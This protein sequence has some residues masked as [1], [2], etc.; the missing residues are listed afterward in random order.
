MPR[1]PFTDIW[2]FLTGATGD[3]MAL[4]VW[5]Y[6]LMALF[7]ALILAS[8]VIAIR[9]WRDDPAQRTAVHFGTWFVRVLIGC[10]WFEGMLWKLPL[11]VSPGLQYWVEQ[12]AKRAAFEFHRDFVTNFIIP[13]LYLFNPLVFLAEFTFAVSLILGL[14]VRLVSAVA[15]L[16][17]LNLWLGIYLPGSPEEWS[18]SYIFL[19]SLMFLFS[20]YA[21]GRSLGFDAW[22][23]REVAAVRDGSGFFGWLLRIAG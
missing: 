9:N 17:V 16:F 7:L 2:Q 21:A 20:L 3:Y 23:R 19:A 11:P 1:N 12:M 15:I 8:L 14:G 10:M 4:G 18:W 6:L 5:R 13:H 22:L